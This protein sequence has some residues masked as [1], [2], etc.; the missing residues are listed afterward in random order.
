MNTKKIARLG[1]SIDCG[2]KRIFSYPGPRNREKREMNGWIAD[3]E[4]L[5]GDW[6]AIG[7]DIRNAAR[8]YTATSQ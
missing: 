3:R 7:G 5:R 1:K 8:R 4:A 2:F 6:Y